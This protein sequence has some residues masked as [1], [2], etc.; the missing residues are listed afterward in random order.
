MSAFAFFVATMTFVPPKAAP[1]FTTAPNSLLMHLPAH[2]FVT[3]YDNLTFQLVLRVV[4]L[5]C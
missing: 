5:S 3:F 2:Y 4:Q 1:A